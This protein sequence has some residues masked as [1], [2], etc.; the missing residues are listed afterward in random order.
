M[1]RLAVT[2]D[3]VACA[4]AMLVTRH[5]S[6]SLRNVHAHLGRGSFT[7]LAKHLE[8]W[9]NETSKE[10]LESQKQSISQDFRRILAQE[11]ARHVRQSVAAKSE[12][13]GRLARS[14]REALVENASLAFQIE[15]REK[16]EERKEQRIMSLLKRLEEEGNKRKNLSIR[17]HEAEKEVSRMNLHCKTGER[18]RKAKPDDTSPASSRT[19]AP[20]GPPKPGRFMTIEEES[21]EGL[22]QKNG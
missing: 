10:S 22:T 2:Y 20:S 4:A 6:P 11:I 18:G 8:T 21:P 17:L 1:K 13:V 9:R 12:E 15:E 19:T 14:L 7:T 5:E 3:D 16:E